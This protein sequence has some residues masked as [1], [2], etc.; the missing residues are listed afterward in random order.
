MKAE[1]EIQS[2]NAKDPAVKVDSL[3]IRFMLPQ[4]KGAQTPKK[5]GLIQKFKKRP[6]KEFWALEDVEFEV[7]KGEILGVIGGNGAG[8]STLLKI[9]AGIFPP[10]RGEVKTRGTV[11][12]L[13]ELGAAFNPELNGLENIYL[14]GSIYRIPRKVIKES[15][16]D[17]IDFSGLR[18]FIRVPVK[19]YSSGMFMRLA[20]SLVIF[21]KPKIVLIDEVFSVGD[22]AFQQK[23]FERVLS[24]RKENASI[25]LVTH[26]AN[27][28]TQI[29]DRVLVLSE[30]KSSFLGG[31]ED[32]VR[33]YRQLI[34]SGEGLNKEQKPPPEPE[35][36]RWGSKEVEI[37]SVDFADQ[38]GQIKKE[39]T[40]GDYFEARIRFE[41]RLQNK[42]PVFGV[43]VST[44]YKLFIYGPNTLEADF[45][46]DI[47]SSGVV[48]F[49]IPELPLM[50]GDYLFS[51]A[52]YDETLS[53][54]YDHHEQMY[55]FRVLGDQ[56]KEFGSVKIR[57]S[58]KLDHE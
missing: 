28:I 20:F 34:Q 1:T 12:P 56:K 27:L 9:I 23:S 43:A 42:A 15:L 45:P 53:K 58:W 14:S 55:H 3:S 51:A 48:R 24:F 25:I 40:P 5:K 36:S 10:T 17:I 30:G 35:S 52:V 44:I 54:A 19:N 47:P 57:S 18:Q 46:K 16:D 49:V 41:S 4:E 37:V 7:Q 21:F 22:E 50:E 31:A 33:H 6:K 38:T 26:D 39:F 13:I 29:C 11:A 32:A 8:K 2:T